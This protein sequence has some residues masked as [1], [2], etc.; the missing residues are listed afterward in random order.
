MASGAEAVGE[1]RK[2]VDDNVGGGVGDR[3]GRPGGAH[4]S[5]RR[6]KAV[7]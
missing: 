3:V 7:R 4:S 2:P 1:F 6:T 5:G